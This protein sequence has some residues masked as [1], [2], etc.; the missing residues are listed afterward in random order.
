MSDPTKKLWLLPKQQAVLDIRQALW[1]SGYR[2]VP[3]YSPEVGGSSPGKWPCG[4]YWTGH[5]RRNPPEAA[6]SAP[7]N[8]RLNTGILGDGLRAADI[9]IDDAETAE[10]VAALALRLLGG[11]PVR[12][13]ENSPRRLLLFRAAEGEPSNGSFQARKGKSKSLGTG[14]N[15]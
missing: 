11:A 1:S 15:S 13:R 6:I 14:N 10:A 8:D 3:V 2:P 9:D 7:K 12:F 5:A 4:D